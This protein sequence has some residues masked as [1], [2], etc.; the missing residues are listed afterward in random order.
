MARARRGRPAGYRR[1][2][3]LV[4]GAGGALGASW[5]TGALPALQERLGVPLGE[6][7]VM[8][9]T[10]AGSVIAAALR[11]GLS[12]DELIAL[13]RGQQV[14]MLTQAGPIEA[15]LDELGIG[16]LPPL[17]RMR[18]GSPELMAATLL[19]PRRVHPLVGAS[20]LLPR[21]R[22]R[23]DS[24]HALVQAM[25]DRARVTGRALALAPAQSPTL[26]PAQSPAQSPEWV[27]RP[28]WI[29]AVDYGTG[30]RVFFGREGA[31]VAPLADA[32]TASC[33]IPAWYEPVRINGRR[34]VD[35]GVRSAT[36]VRALA[37]F[38]VDEV[39]VLAPTASLVTDLPR[40]PYALVE[41][42]VRRAVTKA[43]LNEASVL[44]GL[45]IQ[46]TVITPGPE[47]LAAIGANLMDSR[48]REAVLETSLRTSPLSLATPGG[49]LSRP[50]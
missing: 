29:V 41:R 36:S 19:R 39:Y 21:G 42:R 23:H 34:Y 32:V 15:G 24:L 20:A 31:P 10:S 46:V 12:V 11:C 14:A 8:I 33:S 26:A 27:E 3:G 37:S 13:Q 50:A 18:L 2:I 35:G 38:G 30:R 7:D 4:F 47:D 49:L 17:P 25:H 40:Q 9:G 22:A 1:R 6:V 48:R 45:G 28:T 43:L 5:M 16:R 44:R